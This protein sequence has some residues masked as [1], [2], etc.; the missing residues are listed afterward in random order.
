MS[1]DETA[2]AI[3]TAAIERNA[4]VVVAESLTSGA[5]ATALGHAS[6]A[7][8]WFTGSV[9]AYSPKMKQR[10]LGVRPGPVV[11]ATVAKQMAEGALAAT[12]ASVAVSV[13]GVG[14]PDPEEDQPAGTVFLAC[15][16]TNGVHVHYLHLTGEPE[17]VVEQTVHAALVALL[18]ELV[19]G[20]HSSME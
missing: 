14:G 20:H 7:S 9:V 2:E 16:G 4:T 11:T 12:Q 10:I 8:I 15:G 17:D 6:D 3:A 13:T 19:D 5:I 1:T 18:H